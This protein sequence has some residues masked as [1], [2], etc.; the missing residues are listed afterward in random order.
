M[1][2]CNDI[3]AYFSGLMFGKVGKKKKKSFVFEICSLI[4]VLSLAL[5]SRH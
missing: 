5:F 4:S 2:I 1:I 3:W